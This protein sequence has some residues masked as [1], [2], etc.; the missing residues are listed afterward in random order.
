MAEGDPSADLLAD[1]R[2]I[3][4]SGDV[5]AAA[6][7]L[8]FARWGADVTVFERPDSKLCTATPIIEHDGQQVS[9]LRQS[10]IRR[11]KVGAGDWRDQ[12]AGVDV[13][14][15]DVPLSE[16][17]ELSEL[18]HMA[19]SH[20]HLIIVHSTPFG[21]SG[22]Y[23]EFQADD[24]VLQALGGFAGTNGL[25]GREPLAAPGT[26]IPRAVGVLGA[27]AALA[28]LLERLHSGLGEWIEL[29]SME[30]CSTLIMSMR[31][32]FSGQPVPRGAGP[33]GWAE[34]VETSNGWITLSPWS[35]EVLRHLP[36]AF[37]CD[38]PPEHLLNG[39]ERFAEPDPSREYTLPIVQSH[40]AETVWTK[41]SELGIV[42]A[43]HRTAREL[44][45]DPQLEAL[46]FFEHRDD[47]P[48]LSTLRG[49]RRT[50]RPGVTPA[51]QPRR[52]SFTARPRPNAAT[53][54]LDGLRVV[55]FTHAWLGP[56]AAT[57]LSDL[58]A[59]VIKVEGPKRP[60][61]WR[62]DANEPM[63]VAAPDAH[64]LNV[65]PNFNMANRGKRTVSIA[66]DTEEGRE[67]ALQLIARA[68]LVLE[69]FRPRVLENL[70]LT[71]DEMRAVNPQVALISF[72]GF[73]TGGPYDNYRANGGTT[74]G[75]AGWDLLFGY[76]DGPPLILGTMQADPIVGAQ[77][78]AAALAAA[79][80]VQRESASV[81]V[82]GSMF[83]SAVGYIDEYVLAAS[84]GIDMPA[85]NGNRLADAVPHE[86]FRCRDAADGSEEWIA[87]SVRSDDEWLPLATLG[88]FDQPQWR[89]LSGRQVD[90]LRIESV[91]TSWTQSWDAQTLQHRLQSVGVAAGVVH[92][93]LSHLRDPHLASRDWWLH[94]THPDTGT[95]QYQGYPWQLARNPA[96]CSRPAPRLGGHTEEILRDTLGLDGTMIAR[97]LSDGV[98]SGLQAKRKPGEPRPQP[99]SPR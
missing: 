13:L 5:P 18:Q 48:G 74:E 24:L 15:S 55:D 22:P 69:N 20:P 41:L 72:S 93:T 43:W 38:A 67:L 85:R 36:I 75:N 84:V 50:M 68:D 66:L 83:E 88:G 9:L 27:V 53:G 99:I 28:A 6:C 51:D 37:G 14:I 25:P 61:L 60:D 42:M 76:R 40:D 89:T 95:R 86:C 19:E 63:R 26:I 21:T 45:D 54:P 87:I 16:P 35:K 94:L 98:V 82:Q 97:L 90:E 29:S 52:D 34:V 80:R 39:E 79:W 1:L 46:Q 71:H 73:G 31:S 10:L 77:M 7:G 4:V 56:Y 92:S 96:S 64:P 2:V 30:A 81:H 57:L 65:R 44:L 70:R 49:A 23:A 47:L 59:E 78:A 33:V 3:E 58:G 8:E 91:M 32:E 11:K 62:Y 17:V 12:L